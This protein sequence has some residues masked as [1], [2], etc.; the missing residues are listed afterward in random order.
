MATIEYDIRNGIAYRKGRYDG[1]S[2]T[3]FAYCDRCGRSPIIN[4]KCLKCDVPEP[5]TKA[6]K[7]A[8]VIEWFCFHRSTR[9]AFGEHSGHFES[10][11]S[12]LA[13]KIIQACCGDNIEIEQATNV[14]LK[15][16]K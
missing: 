2:D 4:N 8:K 16:V 14:N 15:E 9:G 10:F 7:L 13:E 3:L 6:R 11:E 5:G 12:N 1:D